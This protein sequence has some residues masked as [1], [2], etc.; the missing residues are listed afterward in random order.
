LKYREQRLN[1]LK[2]RVGEWD[3]LSNN[4]E[5]GH[6]DISVSEIV[7]HPN[8]NNGSMHNDVALIKLSSEVAFQQHVNTICI[9]NPTVQSNYDSES[10][11]VTGWGKHAF[12]QYSTNYSNHVKSNEPLKGLST[13][14]SL[15]GVQ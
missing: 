12:G 13:V 4:T 14:S 8:F 5:Q 10:C 1:E 7:T 11:V 2:V 15:R 6:Q 3:T 9:P